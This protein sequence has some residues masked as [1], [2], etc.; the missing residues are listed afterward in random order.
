MF[1]DYEFNFML[2][3]ISSLVEKERAEKFNRTSA[4][5]LVQQEQQKDFILKTILNGALLYFPDFSKFI[6]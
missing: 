1:K 6:H 3:G 5:S 4:L 2:W